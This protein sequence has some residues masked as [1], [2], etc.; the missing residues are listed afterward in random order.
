MT[1]EKKE[2]DSERSG[3]GTLEW[4]EHSENVCKGCSHL[5]LYCFAAHNAARFKWRPRE[6]WGREELT[7]KALRT[8]YPKRTGQIM[9]PTTHDITPGTLEASTRFLKLMLAAGNQVLIVSKPHLECVQH[10]CAELSAFRNQIMFRFTI[11]SMDSGVT[12]FWEPCAPLP[13]E[14]LES[15]QHAYTSG[16]RTSVSCEPLLG[17]L[18]TAQAILAHVRPFVT[19]S[20]WIGKMNR[21]RSRVDISD[22]AIEK[23]VAAIES[24]QT[25]DRIIAMHELLKSDPLI[26]WKDSIKKV[27]TKEASLG[28]ERKETI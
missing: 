12:S 22:P 3:F 2:F 23:Q 20:V 7:K 9:F 25:D 15:L 11:G 27:V 8:S 5:C 17:G 16:Y 14:R 13:A 26:Y 4:S 21:I 1:E 6:E 28:Q 19:D 24:E 10:L 18:A